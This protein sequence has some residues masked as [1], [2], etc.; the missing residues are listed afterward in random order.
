MKH[1]LKSHAKKLSRTPAHRIDLL[2]NLVSQLLHHEQ[3]V[4]T[5]AK[6]K[7]VKPAAEKVINWAK[8]GD[9]KSIKKATFAILDVAQR[10]PLAEDEISAT[11]NSTLKKLFGPLV[12]R[13]STRPSGYVRIQRYGF[14]EPGSDHAPK[15]LVTLVDSPNDVIHSLAA[16]NIKTLH[17]EL[18]KLEQAKYNAVTIQLTDPV[19]GL[20]TT[21]VQL[22]PRHDLNPKQLGHLNAK[23]IRLQTLLR[24]YDKS[25]AS[26]PAARAAEARWR[27]TLIKQAEGKRDALEEELIADWN[28]VGDAGMDQKK[29][30]MARSL[31]LK[32][33]EGGIITRTSPPWEQAIRKADGP[34]TAISS[35][36]SIPNAPFSKASQKA[37]IEEAAAESSQAA[38]PTKA[39]EVDKAEEKPKGAVSGFLK[40]IGVDWS[41]W[42]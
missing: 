34:K 31:G 39:D 23:E 40:R 14:N 42:T 1:G 7:F 24:K 36:R 4:T 12:A 20:P 25:M 17:D 10:H 9:E 5:V 37:A 8:K 28:Q 22:R 2:R 30:K 15:A 26:F 27:K 32:M 11:Y 13:Y 29:V 16:K 18:R 3:I 6:A 41:R 33:E 19:T 21:S 38:A 35:S